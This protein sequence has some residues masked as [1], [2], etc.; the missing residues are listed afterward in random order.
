[1]TDHGKQ[2][3]EDRVDYELS[4]LTNLGEAMDTL[5]RAFYAHPE[6]Q[7]LLNRTPALGHELPWTLV[8]C[9]EPSVSV[10]GLVVGGE[11]DEG[12]WDLDGV[13]TIFT[14][15]HVPTG[16][17]Q[18][19]KGWCGDVWVQGRLPGTGP[20]R[21]DARILLAELERASCHWASSSRLKARWAEFAAFAGEKAFPDAFVEL[22]F[23]DD[24]YRGLIV[25][26]RVDCS[27]VWDFNSL[28]TLLQPDGALV[29]L[30]AGQAD[31]V[32]LL[33]GGHHA[34]LLRRA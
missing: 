10:T 19:I 29:S 25:D 1:M 26:G 13:F 11:H 9:A 2:A 15:E 14:C 21:P 31:S 3:P 16:E 32:A 22:R 6:A 34:D 33:V 27:G 5:R 18:T 8:R 30:E 24:C 28:L 7:T 12:A 17:F 23:A 4:L 20:R